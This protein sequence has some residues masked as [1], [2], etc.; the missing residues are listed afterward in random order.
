MRKF[1]DLSPDPSSHI[2]TLMRIGYTLPSAISDILDN[3]IAAEANNIDV[4]SPPGR[5]N[6]II[7]ILDD[8]IGM[9]P[10]ELVEN[11]R[12]G[13]KDPSQDREEGDL[14]RFG[15][16]MKTASFSQARRLTVISKKS[17]FPVTAATWD[18]DVIEQKN[19]WALEIIKGDA[20]KEIPDVKIDE[21]TPQGTQVIWENL[22]HLS[23]GNHAGSP[24]EELATQLA[25]VKHHIALYFH[26]F[27]K[28]RNCIVIRLNGLPIDPIDPFLTNV[29][30]Y[31]EGREASFRCRGGFV[32]IK[33]H[34]LPHINRI[35][36]RHLERLGGADGLSRNQGIYIYREDRLINAGGW[37]GLATKNQLGA[38]A[39]VQVDIPSSLDHEWST[40]VKKSSLQI[41]SRVRR[42]LKK[43]LSDPIKRSKKTFTYRGT[44]DTA[45][46]YWKV[47]EDKNEHKVTY[48]VDPDNKTL[49]SILQA[50]SPESRRALLTY[51][52]ELSSSIPI[53]HIYQKMSESPKDIQ[54]ETVNT[55]IFDSILDKIFE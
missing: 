42:D 54:Q 37:L 52:S 47:C 11:M 49:I 23:T 1:H 17:G 25:G 15:S 19:A 46:A 16:G 48:H 22:S 53:N 28:G 41:P 20:V 27:I 50:S 43:Y 35:P 21:K 36:K 24:D 3:S 10:D 33:T 26:R 31:Q 32:K 38:L 30:G 14:G 34:V 40:D 45:N 51:L 39:R 7:S 55:S 9:S 4:T 18:I 8:G 29:D 13:C 12:L 44:K 5:K 6:P 2:K